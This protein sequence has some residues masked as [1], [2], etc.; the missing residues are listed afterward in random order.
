MSARVTFLAGLLFVAGVSQATAA[1]T[2]DIA[3]FEKI[4]TSD[5]QTGNLNKSVH[6]RLVAELSRAQAACIAGHDADAI[7]QLAAVKHRF[8]YR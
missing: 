7:R 3:D 1:C 6:Q 2:G 4:I 5:V 8:G